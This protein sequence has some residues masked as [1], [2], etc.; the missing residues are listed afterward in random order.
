MRPPHTRD[1]RQAL[2]R[3]D[4]PFFDV[5][6]HERWLCPAWE[7]LPWTF[8]VWVADAGWA[9]VR[10]ANPPPCAFKLRWWTVTIIDGATLEMCLSEAQE[11][12]KKRLKE[13]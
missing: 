11:L 4:L 10:D 6:H 5:S 12:L 8:L 3:A 7:L 13:V 1:V 2:L 9:L